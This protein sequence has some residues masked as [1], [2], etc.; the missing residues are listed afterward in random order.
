MSL[1]SLVRRVLPPEIR[2]ALRRAIGQLAPVPS[3]SAS[4]KAPGY[5]R[6]LAQELALFETRVEVHDLPP[7]FHYWSNRYLRPKFESLG[8]SHPDAFF[9][10]FL[11]RAYHASA[12]GTRRFVSIGAGNCD[13][14]VR[15]AVELCRRGLED[16][17]IECVEINPAMLRRGEEHSRREGVE[18]RIR[19]VTGDFNGWSA[20]G[21][22]DAVMANQS[23]HHVT[24]LEGLFDAVAKAIEG[25]GLF[26]VSDM[27]GRNGHQRWPEALAIVREFWTELPASYRFNVQLHRQEDDFLDWDCSSEG[28]EG[29]RSQDILPLMIERFSFDLFAPY[30]NVIDPFVDR[31]FGHHFDA[32]GTWDRAFI[33]RVHERDEREIRRGAIKPTHLV[34]VLGAGRTGERIYLEGLTPE[35][36]VR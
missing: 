6:Q 21:R 25:P 15:L 12:G 36:C 9:T 26:A 34:A 27:I 35:A 13:T 14:E 31:N 22:C 33:D 19:T 4:A 17:V 7:I 32:E 28:F 18:A 16:F 8:F 10:R 24:N 5:D 29:I 1:R 30:A 23:L 2:R 11:E 3:P 20:D